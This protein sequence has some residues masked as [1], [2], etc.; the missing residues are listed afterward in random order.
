MRYRDALVEERQQPV[1]VRLYVGTHDRRHELPAQVGAKAMRGIMVLD[2][3][4]A[5]EQPAVARMWVS[6]L[7]LVLSIG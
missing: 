4:Q 6:R 3:G 2:L 7:F 5:I 1:D